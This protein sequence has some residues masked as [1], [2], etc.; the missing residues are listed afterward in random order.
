M[1]LP[2]WASRSRKEDSIWITRSIFVFVTGSKAA[3][4][5]LQFSLQLR[6][7]LSFVSSCLHLLGC[8]NF[9]PDPPQLVYSVSGLEP[10]AS[11][12]L[13]KH[14]PDFVVLN[15]LITFIYW[16]VCR[17]LCVFRG[18]RTTQTHMSLFSPTIGGYLGSHS[19]LQTWIWQAHVCVFET[20][21]SLA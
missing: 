6:L 2:T 8:Q 1:P 21:F 11:Y 9:R 15:F 20:R 19:G 16:C 12:T 10:K 3:Q 17:V 4:A 14:Y 5:A 18:W 13:N 7:A